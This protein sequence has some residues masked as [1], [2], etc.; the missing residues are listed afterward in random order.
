MSGLV[1]GIHVLKHKESD[2]RIRGWLGRSDLSVPSGQWHRSN[3]WMGEKPRRR[4][5]GCCMVWRKHAWGRN[6]GRAAAQQG[7]AR[8]GAVCAARLVSS[9]FCLAQGSRRR[10]PRTVTVLLG[11]QQ[12]CV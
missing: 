9:P 11:R 8:R 3:Q 7:G 5:G 12:D 6:S 10:N 4:S 1:P 2:E